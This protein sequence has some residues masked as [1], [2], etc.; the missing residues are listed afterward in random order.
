MQQAA[1]SADNGSISSATS[2]RRDQSSRRG[3]ARPWS[4]DGRDH[5]EIASCV[6]VG[7]VI[8]SGNI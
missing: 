6:L 1:S 8:F 4:I 7:H 3:L 5:A 2:K